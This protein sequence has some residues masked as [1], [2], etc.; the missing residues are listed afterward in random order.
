MEKDTYLESLY[1]TLEM[2]DL[3]LQNKSKFPKEQVERAEQIKLETEGFI[4]KRESIPMEQR[5]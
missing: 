2:C 1:T 4:K 3:V 5:L